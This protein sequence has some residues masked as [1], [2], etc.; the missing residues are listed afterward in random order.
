MYGS[1]SSCYLSLILVLRFETWSIFLIYELTVYHIKII[2]IIWIL[3][4][5]H[6]LILK[7][8]TLKR[9][10]WQQCEFA[11]YYF[12]FRER[13]PEMYLDLP[14]RSLLDPLLSHKRMISSGSPTSYMRGIDILDFLIDSFIWLFDR[15]FFLLFDFLFFYFFQGFWF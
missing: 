15:F 2:K 13:N 6:K 3:S 1:G 10:S 14:T 5:L 11:N 8:K 4:L 9:Y 12:Q 7:F